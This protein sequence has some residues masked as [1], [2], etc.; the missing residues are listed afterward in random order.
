MSAP[1]HLSARTLR[2]GT[3]RAA[4]AGIALIA[5]AACTIEVTPPEP[6]EIPDPGFSGDWVASILGSDMILRIGE[7]R[8]I[9][10]PDGRI[11]WRDID[12]G[13]SCLLDR[14]VDPAQLSCTVVPSVEGP[15]CTA[16]AA[17]EPYVEIS[18]AT[19]N[20]RIVAEVGGEL[21]PG[22]GNPCDADPIVSWDGPVA[23]TFFPG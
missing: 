7:F 20:G 16:S 12:W 3:V 13:L 10:A 9:A 8:G 15:T 1:R 5:A 6:E 2:A 23:A 4:I 17:N 18:L 14:G 22:N 19:P 21:R 11:L